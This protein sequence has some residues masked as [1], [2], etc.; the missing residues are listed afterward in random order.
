M[1]SR[2]T[3]RFA[4]ASMFALALYGVALAAD[5][6]RTTLGCTIGEGS[7]TDRQLEIRNGTG[8]ALKAETVINYDLYWKKP[9]MQGESAGCFAIPRDLGPNLQVAQKVTLSP[10]AEPTRC[11]AYVSPKF[12]TVI[13]GTDKSTEVRCDP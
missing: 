5:G 2:T 13:H 12:P 9:T 11:I 3:A 1:T 10:G 8:Q 4:S 7:G 6:Q